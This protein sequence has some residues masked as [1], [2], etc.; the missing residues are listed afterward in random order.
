MTMP[1]MTRKTATPTRPADGDRLWRVGVEGAPTWDDVR[2]EA[3]PFYVEP[4]WLD[5]YCNVAQDYGVFETVTRGR[6]DNESH[7]LAARTAARALDIDTDTEILLSGNT[8]QRQ[9]GPDV[10]AARL[11]AHGITGRG[12]WAHNAALGYAYS[13]VTRR[14]SDEKE[15]GRDQRRQT[16]GSCGTVKPD[17]I[18]RALAPNQPRLLPA[19]CYNQPLCDSCVAK[20]IVA[21]AK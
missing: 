8:T 14:A 4:E 16:C 19:A 15:A 17:V 20:V 6:D 11:K 18:I 12:V 7:A 10:I 1:S 9:V 21:L 3:S 13:Q 2:D 5:D